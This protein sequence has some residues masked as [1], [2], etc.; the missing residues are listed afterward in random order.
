MTAAAIPHLPSW[1]AP[2][3]Y[4]PHQSILS[5]AAGNSLSTPK[6]AA[7]NEMEKAGASHPAIQ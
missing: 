6:G 1:N 7:E 4:R 2:D 5:R 3:R